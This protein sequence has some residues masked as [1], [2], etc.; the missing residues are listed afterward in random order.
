MASKRGVYSVKLINSAN[1][2]ATGVTYSNE[3]SFDVTVTDP[4]LTTTLTDFALPP[5]S[6]EAGLTNIFNF[7][8]VTDSAAIAVSNP[9]ICGARTYTVYKIDANNAEV[10]QA[11]VTFTADP[12]GAA[13]ELK[14]L[15]MNEDQDVGVHNMRL[16][17]SLPDALYPKLIKNF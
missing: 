12:T 14:T 4:C 11:I 10:A 17:V 1:Y 8:E 16:V 15:T 3:I 6:I 13:H 2:A 9:T 7:A 5:V